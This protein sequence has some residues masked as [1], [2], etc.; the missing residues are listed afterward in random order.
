MRERNRSGRGGR[1]RSGGDGEADLVATELSEVVKQA[2]ATD[3]VAT[4]AS[5]PPPA[6]AEIGLRADNPPATSLD[7]LAE[8][9]TAQVPAESAELDERPEVL[10]TLE[11]L[12]A[13]MLNEF[14]Y[15]PR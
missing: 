5:T 1:R 6:S 11:P 10:P 12:P 8:T 15:C 4:G 3:E 9:E 7:M 14:V 13:R 2:F